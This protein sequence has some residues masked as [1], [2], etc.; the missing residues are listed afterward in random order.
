MKPLWQTFQVLSSFESGDPDTHS[1]PVRVYGRD[2][3]WLATLHADAD[4]TA[5]SLV[6]DVRV[7]L[8]RSS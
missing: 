2:G 8:A 5:S 7:A 4:L 1:A 6:H 3:V